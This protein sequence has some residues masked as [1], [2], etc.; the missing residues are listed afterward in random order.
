MGS[1]QRSDLLKHI[2]GSAYDSLLKIVLDNSPFPVAVVDTK[3]EQIYFWSKSA[4]K[5]FGHNPKTTQEWY[6]LA[7]PD[8]KYRKEVISRWKPFLKI[9]NESTEA[10]NTGEYHITCNDGTIKICELYAQIIPN[11]LIVTLNDI[12][13]SKHAAE[14]YKKL[15][16][17]LLESQQ[18]LIATKDQAENNE[19]YYHS[20][21]NNIG[22]PFFIKDDQSRIIFENEAFCKFVD[23]T[24]ASILGKTLAEDVAPE[25]QEN[26]LKIDKQVIKSGKES[27]TEEMITIRGGQTQTI[28]T[29]K[30]RFINNGKKLIIGIIRDISEHKNIEKEIKAANQQLLA[31]E[32]Q[33]RAAN[34]Q[35]AANE[36]QLRAANQHL[37]ANEQKLRISEKRFKRSEEIGHVGN[38][39]YNIQTKHFWGS[40]EAKRIYGLHLNAYDF[41]TEHVESCIPERKRVHEALIDLIENDKPYDL[42]FEII[43]KDKGEK[44]Y[45]HSIAE[46]E[47][48]S[49]GKPIK[50]S[51]IIID[52]TNLKK[53][54]DEIKIR[55][56]HLRSLIENPIGYLIYRTRLDRETG[57]IEVVQV[58]PSF[59]EVLGLP[60]T[61]RDH[62]N[63]WFAHV[64][65]EDLPN[66]LKASENGMRPPF[67]LHVDARYNHPT[68]G[69]KWFDIR[70]NGIPFADD[71]NLIEYA[72]GIIL[73]I[74]DRKIAEQQLKENQTQ[75]RNII[76]NSTN[77]F[78]AHSTENILTFVSPQVREYLGCEP[79]EAKK[80]WTTFAT[81]NPINKKAFELTQ[82][83]IKTGKRQA[84]YALE[85]QR[86]DGQHILVE[87][88]EAPV[89]ENGRVTGIVGSLVDITERKKA[90]EKISNISRRLKISTES[91]NIGTWEL[92]LKKNILSWDKQMFT[93]YGIEP[94]AFGGAYEAWKKGVHPDDIDR[95][96][97]EVQDA[98]AGK[99][100]FHT[101]FRIV[102]PDGQIRFIE[103]HAIVTRDPDG[104]PNSMI[105]VN[106]DITEQKSAE[107]N[108]IKAKEKAEESDR[109]KS[110]FLANMSHEI[111]TPM[112]GILGFTSLLEKP[113][114]TDDTREQYIQI[115]QKSGKRMLDTVNDL[116]NISKIETGLE[117]LHPE[118]VNPCDL[119]KEIVDFFKPSADAKGLKIIRETNCKDKVWIDVTKF[120]SIVSNLIKNALKF[121]EN[122]SIYLSNKLDDTTMVLSVKDT[123]Q[124]I[125]IDRQEAI[126][127]RFI[128]ADIYDTMAFEGSGLGLSIVKAYVEMMNGTIHLESELGKGSCFTIKIP[129]KI[130]NKRIEEK[131]DIS[132]EK[133]SVAFH[134]ILI[135]EDDDISYQHLM[136]SLSDHS[137]LILR[138][139]DGI[140][141]V[142][143]AQKQKDIDLILMDI[144]MPKMNGYDATEA[145]RKFNKDV[146][147]VA[148]TAYA[149]PE[150]EIKA[151][152]V[153]CNA[154]I[155]KPIDIDVLLRIVS[156]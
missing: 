108:L 150:D 85:L 17:R 63:N 38:W 107:I 120:N 60:E 11:Y 43:S 138:A 31:N 28:Y 122:G 91:A 146:M 51:G 90:E 128:Q 124:G 153:G 101:Q 142:K 154:Y 18:Q 37:S 49:K 4:H 27:I 80:L 100:D 84:T 42:E 54:N 155:S 69:L 143:L 102:W 46:L 67:K 77:M 98:I 112:N 7:Y 33:L 97:A 2:N 64:H 24:E 105:G 147:I 56:M 87:V 44:K 61:D 20:I 66:L 70:S 65:P 95:S 72:N 19:K 25:E 32:Q 88:R 103:A 92:D 136:I 59:T 86:K 151:K 16:H 132:N 149:M 152:S 71:P 35:L 126:F 125:A 68:E 62:F 83:A 119:I 131:Q 118:A 34:Q 1:K 13:E 137:D 29:R 109:L 117:E 58:S 111:R 41:T 50:V 22:D 130:Q 148:Q 106:W 140:E 82:R 104:A 6:K 127:D 26:F 73:D 3:D 96:D 21:L 75:L 53:A 57:Q 89:V 135:A 133:P 94:D 139:M 23:L 30:S 45:I 78:Y 14:I 47:R 81:D 115:I 8:P 93:L 39:E 55:E 110:A 36:Q 123:G 10:I 5:L 15:D 52:I 116:I 141:A 114:L 134:K 145:I 129:I 99:K 9:A 74:T 48:D 76:E 12:T 40:D 156:Q 79:E 121:T 113:N 144:K